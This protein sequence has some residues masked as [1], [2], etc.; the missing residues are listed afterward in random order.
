M[1]DMSIE[2]FGLRFKN[3]VVL[4]SGPSGNGKEAMEV[5]DLAELGGFTTKTVTWKP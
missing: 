5:F 2:L 3:P 4:A 1:V